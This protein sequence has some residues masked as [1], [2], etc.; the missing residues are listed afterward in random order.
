MG[1]LCEP[2]EE[3]PTLPEQVRTQF[4]GSWVQSVMQG[5]P[6]PGIEPFLSSLSV[7]ERASSRSWSQSTGRSARAVEARASRHQTTTVGPTTSSPDASQQTEVASRTESATTHMPT[8][9]AGSRGADGHWQTLG[10]EPEGGRRAAL[11]TTVA[12]YEILEV[13][14]RGG[15]GVAY[16]ARQ[17][18]AS[19]GSQVG[20][21]GRTRRRG[22][23]GPV[24]RRG[25]ST[26]RAGRSPSFTSTRW[27]STGGGRCRS[28]SFSGRDTTMQP[29]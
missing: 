1:L 16:R 2:E 17:P 5:D 20:R 22:G 23:A 10:G 29:K 12:G 3:Q 8:G 25:T 21:D 28:G 27:A 19:R 18:G 7:Q 9:E 4:V 24:S 15:M 26:R 6:A 14:A 13:L 11:P